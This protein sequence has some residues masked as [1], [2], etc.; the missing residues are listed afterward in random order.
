[1]SLQKFRIEGLPPSYNKSFNIIWGLKEVSLS[2]EAHAFKNRVKINMPYHNYGKDLLQIDI[3][4]NYNWYC[5]NRN[6]KKFDTQNCDK[7]V[8]D[9]ISESLGIDDSRFKIRNVLDV[10]NDKE[11]FTLIEINTLCPTSVAMKE[12]NF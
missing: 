1:M 11:T 4:Y 9:A 2:P 7:L 8:I 12:K 3:T 5:K 10:H 6:L